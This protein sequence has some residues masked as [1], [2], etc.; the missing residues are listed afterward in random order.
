MTAVRRRPASTRGRARRSVPG[1][2]QHRLSSW[3][4]S[5]PPSVRLARRRRSTL[6]S[7]R[8]LARTV[9][10]HRPP[11]WRPVGIRAG[12][13]SSCP[14]AARGSPPRVRRARGI[15]RGLDVVVGGLAHRT[16]A[17]LLRVLPVRRRRRHPDHLPRLEILLDTLPD[18]LEGFWLNVKLFMVAEVLVLVWA[19]VV[20]LAPVAPRPAAARRS[21]SWP[22][23]TSTSSAACPPSSRSTWSG[24]ACQPVEAA[25][26]RQLSR[27]PAVLARGA[28]L[29]LVYGAYVAEVYRAGIE[30]I[31]WSQTAAARSLGLSHGQT[32]RYVIIPQAVRRVIPPLLN[33]FIG[34]QKDT[35]LVSVIGLLEGSTG[36]SS[37]SSNRCFNLSPIVGLGL[38]F[39]VITIP[40]T[41]LTDYL[42]ARAGHAA[43]TQAT[44]MPAVPRDRRRGEALRRQPGAAGRRPRRRR[45]RGDLPHRRVGVRAS[46][47]CCAASTGWSRSTRGAIASTAT[48]SSGRDVDLNRLRQDVGIVFQSFNLFPHMTVLENVTLAP[49]KVLGLSQAR[50]RRS[51]PTCCSPDRAREKAR[52]VP[53]PA[54]GRP[55]A[56]GGDR[57]G[58]G[59]A[60]P[61][62]AARR[63]HDARSTPSSSPRCSTSCASWRPRA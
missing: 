5:S 49:R 58:A 46:R 56:A 6:P 45:A 23:P 15:G 32:M 21:G 13:G 10:A 18:L 54:V 4:P 14:R 17:R 61:A 27:D 7:D 44:L 60:A 39:V 12:A 52:R 20:A 36:R 28:S 1:C 2:E 57:A 41:R 29:V 62:D 30:S 3:R 59:H 11:I 31:H 25:D 22:S 34:L 8:T 24:S 35:A 53:R 63:D 51:A 42:V 38:C 16:G 43:A 47:R 37:T 19:M 55:A 40:M 26:R 50:R 33:D 9:R 48:R